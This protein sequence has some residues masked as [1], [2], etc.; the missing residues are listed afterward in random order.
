[1][2]P[3]LLFSPVS[4][5]Q[6]R[7]NNED[8]F[9]SP[10]PPAFT[11][12]YATDSESASDGEAGGGAD[13]Y[14]WGTEDDAEMPPETQL[15]PQSSADDFSFLE[16][17]TTDNDAASIPDIATDNDTDLPALRS[18]SECS[19][20]ESEDDDDLPGLRTVS[21][22]DGSDIES[23]S[24]VAIA[25]S[26]RNGPLISAPAGRSRKTPSP[27]P[28]VVP[29]VD[30]KITT[31]WTVETVEQRAVRL[32][33]DARRFMEDREEKLMREANDR[34]RQKAKEHVQGNER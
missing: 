19:M 2:L 5:L 4:P 15:S 29:S 10:T 11:N 21:C 25:R 22:S 24:D 16:P 20:S 31:Y 32:E 8:V 1:M 33:R 6:A 9:G 23:G 27:P 13:E 18:E 30:Q 34:R 3:Q 28:P 26:Q 12:G 17:P 7:T 14:V